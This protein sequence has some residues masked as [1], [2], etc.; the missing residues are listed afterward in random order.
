MLLMIPINNLR[1]FLREGPCRDPLQLNILI[2]QL[3]IE[4]LDERD[5]I[6]LKELIAVMKP[7]AKYLDV[8]LGKQNIFLGCVLPCILKL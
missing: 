7:S 3:E 8:L 2:T 6:V 5:R 4:N 1:L